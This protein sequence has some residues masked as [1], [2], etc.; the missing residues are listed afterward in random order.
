MLLIRPL[1]PI[2]RAG[3]RLRAP[4]RFLLVET[5]PRPRIGARRYVFD[6][7]PTVIRPTALLCAPARL[8]WGDCEFIA[9][10]QA[11]AAHHMA[12]AARDALDEDDEEF[13][14]ARVAVADTRAECEALAYGVYTPEPLTI[15]DVFLRAEMLTM[16]FGSG[17]LSDLLEAD[18]PAH[19]MLGGLLEA[20]WKVGGAANV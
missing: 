9:V 2:P 7:M 5:S 3:R 12:I 13:G 17:R 16:H 10:R 4:R 1:P 11:V 20:C 6:D 8:S 18:D 14:F 19:R 15:R